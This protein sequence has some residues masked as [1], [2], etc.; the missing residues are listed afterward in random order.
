MP[1]ANDNAQNNPM[2]ELLDALRLGQR[3]GP[4]LDEITLRAMRE[5]WSPEKFRAALQ[6]VN[7]A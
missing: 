2:A 1:A 3:V 5:D 7:L 4:T 6:E